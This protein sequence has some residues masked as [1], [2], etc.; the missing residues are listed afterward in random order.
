MASDAL[1]AVNL[2]RLDSLLTGTVE[3]IGVAIQSRV[4]K[5]IA[6]DNLG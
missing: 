1:C 5:Q 4:E 2:L 3:D 6:T